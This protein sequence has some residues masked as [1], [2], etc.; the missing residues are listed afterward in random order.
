MEA[1]KQACSTGLGMYGAPWDSL[2][3]VPHQAV[4]SRAERWEAFLGPGVGWC[5]ETCWE[6]VVV[7]LSCKVLM[8]AVMALLRLRLDSHDLPQGPLEAH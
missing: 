7:V 1:H 8:M 2:V 4:Y 3:E 6:V 5:C